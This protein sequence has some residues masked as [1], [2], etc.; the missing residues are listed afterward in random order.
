MESFP[1]AFPILERGKTPNFDLRS[2]ISPDIGIS[3][4]RLHLGKEGSQLDIAGI[5]PLT[6]SVR[7]RLT[8]LPL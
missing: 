8:K 5:G 3:K 2:Y 6:H 1:T 4:R 7:F